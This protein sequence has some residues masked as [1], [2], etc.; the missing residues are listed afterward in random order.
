M[1]RVRVRVCVIV[2]VNVRVRVRDKFRNWVRVTVR[3]IIM[4][5]CYG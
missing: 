3:I 2:K 4:G 5:Y 1:V